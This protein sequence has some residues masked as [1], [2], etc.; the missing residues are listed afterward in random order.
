M[1]KQ[2]IDSLKKFIL[3]SVAFCLLSTTFAQ[4]GW[5][6]KKGKRGSLEYFIHNEQEFNSI[7]QKIKPGDHVMITNGVYTVSYTH[8][9]LPTILRV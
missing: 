8:L 7:S 5:T 3:T 1:H 4:Q 2:I 9:T 6:S